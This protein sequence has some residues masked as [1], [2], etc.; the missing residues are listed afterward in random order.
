MIC[1][2]ATAKKLLLVNKFFCPGMEDHFCLY[3]D[4]YHEGRPT[5]DGCDGPDTV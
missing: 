5:M 1:S 4:V 3:S 2:E